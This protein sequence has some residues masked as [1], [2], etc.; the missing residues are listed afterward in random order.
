MTSSNSCRSARVA[1]A[2]YWA[3]RVFSTAFSLLQD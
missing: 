1:A 3:L 2:R